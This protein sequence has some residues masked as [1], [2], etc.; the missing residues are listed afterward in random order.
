MSNL[1]AEPGEIDCSGRPTTGVD[2]VTPRKVPLGGIRAMIV[3]RT[4]PTRDRSMIGAWCFADHY[5][6]DPVSDSGG[7]RVYPHPHTGLQTVS[8]LF[9]GEI[10]HRDSAGVHAMV[11]P[12]E[13]NLMSAGHGI[14]HSEMSTDATTVLHGVQL[15]VALPDAVRDDPHGFQ[16]HAPESAPLGDAGSVRVFIGELVGTSSPIVTATPLLGAEILLEPHT[17]VVLPVRSDFEHGFLLDT[18][19]LVVDDVDLAHGDLAY[20]GPGVSTIRLANPSDTVARVILLGGT[21]F[22][23][24]IIMWWNFVGRTHEEIVE[25]REEWESAATRFGTVDGWTSDDR[26]PA[27]PLP[28]SRLK[29]R[30]R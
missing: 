20:V 27:P 12:G 18:E 28:T 9:E 2:V 7:M 4:L 13:I 14:S 10:E 24:D 25:Y 23:E 6:P 1:D 30:K 5:G 22:G 15:W 11:L 19:Q 8:W 16:H 17:E 26:I 29:P 21:P 3:N